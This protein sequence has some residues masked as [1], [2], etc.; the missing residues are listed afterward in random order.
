[1]RPAHARHSKLRSRGAIFPRY[2]SS[3]PVTATA[4]GSCRSSKGDPSRQAQPRTCARTWHASSRRQRSARSLSS[5][6]PSAEEESVRLRPW[7]AFRFRDYRFLWVAGFTSTVAMWMRILS[8]TQWITN[9]TGTPAA[10]AI[11]GVVQLLVQIP[12]LLY[13]GALSDK[14]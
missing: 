2:C 11:V 9:E 4:T 14:I 8:T 12:S 1:G 13:G 7:D 6:S 5:S 3:P 10:L